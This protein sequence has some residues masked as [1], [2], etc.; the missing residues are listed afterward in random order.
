MRQVRDGSRS[1][2]TRI[3][4]G[5]S[6][7]VAD[8]QRALAWRPVRDVPLR[9]GKLLL[10]GLVLLVFVSSCGG[11]QAKPAT[12]GG[13]IGPGRLIPTVVDPQNFVL[14]DASH[15]HV[16]LHS[17]TTA[18]LVKDLGAV[19]GLTSNG[20]ALS[21]DGGYL[22]VTVDR[23]PATLLERINTTN[24][25]VESIGHGE[26]P[27]ISPNGHY[28]AHGGGAGDGILYVRD[29]ASGEVRSINVAKLLGHQDDLINASITWLADGSRIV[30]LPGAVGNDLM[31]GTTPPPIPGSCSAIPI[32]DTCLIVA[33]VAPDHPLTAERVV[34]H[35]LRVPDL[36][37]GDDLA[38]SVL[39]A[40]DQTHATVIDRIEVSGDR[41]DYVR[42]CS[43]S[44]GLSVAFDPRGT[45]LL[46]LI[47]HNPVSLW[48]VG[49]TN[50]DLHAQHRLLANADLQDVTW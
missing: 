39:A 48:W 1:D 9:V 12:T 25:Q 31:G 20:L 40:S 4:D 33:N 10:A 47:G 43:L 23:P 3:V 41:A 34:V 19:D 36:L 46:Y 7:W 26:Q 6:V 45:E 21:P 5:V 42:M 13:P 28:L 17:A 2:V 32:S 44:P 35:G 11:G 16:E 37:S 49:L 8:R 27:A 15:S 14:V 18:A 38:H 29:L 30:V 24:G 50:C 22:Y